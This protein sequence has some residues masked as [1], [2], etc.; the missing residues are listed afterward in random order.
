MQ[1]GFLLVGAD[2]PLLKRVFDALVVGHALISEWLE[3][4]EHPEAKKP[5]HSASS[6]WRTPP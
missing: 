2:S 3:N 4:V 5:Q 6:P 1:L